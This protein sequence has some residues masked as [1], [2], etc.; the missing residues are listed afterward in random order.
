MRDAPSAA[1]VQGGLHLL[2]HVILMAHRPHRIL[3]H[4]P[5]QPRYLAHHAGSSLFLRYEP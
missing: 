5:L 3:E 4:L 2:S 1:T